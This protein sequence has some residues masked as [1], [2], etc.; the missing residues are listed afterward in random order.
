MEFLIFA[1]VA[2]IAG[3]AKLILDSSPDSSKDDSPFPVAQV[4]GRGLVELKRKGMLNPEEL[5]LYCEY[6]E[7]QLE[8]LGNPT[9]PNQV[10]RVPSPETPTVQ[11]FPQVPQS[12]P[13]TFP[14]SV[15]Q[16][17]PQSSPPNSPKDSPEDS[18]EDSPVEWD[19][20]DEILELLATNPDASKS[21]IAFNVFGLTR[22][23]KSGSPN[24]RWMQAMVQIDHCKG[25]L[26]TARME[27]TKQQ[28][29]Q[30]MEGLN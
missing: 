20:T 25:L 13:Q 21:S 8:R 1:A 14:Q 27:S 18:P 5:S 12:F 29:R 30:L 4:R 3:T 19:P 6:L 26:E 15:P 17:V 24:S 16:S 23:D 11:G 7:S 22:D 10:I 9:P 28:L 2:A